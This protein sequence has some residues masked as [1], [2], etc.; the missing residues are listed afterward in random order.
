MN[1]HKPVV[2]RGA[3]SHWPALRTWTLPFLAKLGVTT[4]VVVATSNEER[5]PTTKETTTLGAYVAM[6]QEPQQPQS[7][8]QSQAQSRTCTGAAT[9]QACGCSG[10]GSTGARKLFAHVFTS[11]LC[12]HGSS[13][14]N[15]R[16][17]QLPPPDS[18][19]PP[20]VVPYLKQY[21]LLSAFPQ[22]RAHLRL[23]DLVSRFTLGTLYAWLG[24]R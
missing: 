5:E 11:F 16:L 2:L 12:C 22:L 21:D 14:L 4:P 1:C 13:T 17:T 19:V 9:S 24:A 23:Y 8:S 18:F 20:S 3:A 6:L 10:S 7:Q 15:Q